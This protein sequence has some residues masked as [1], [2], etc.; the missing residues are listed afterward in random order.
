MV[1]KVKSLCFKLLY[2]NEDF[3]MLYGI[4]MTLLLLQF[5]PFLDFVMD[6]YSTAS[7][8]KFHELTIYDIC[9]FG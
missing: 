3:C 5:S 9:L 7:S 1:N 6:G 4:D 8:Y 2:Y